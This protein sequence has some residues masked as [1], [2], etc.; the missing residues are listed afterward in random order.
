MKR[1]ILF[2]ALGALALLSACTKDPWAQ[3]EE[4]SWNNDHRILNIKFAGQAGLA[5]VKDVDESTGTVNVQLATDLVPDMS[6]VTL[7]TLELSYKASCN[8]ERG[9][10][11]DFSGAAPVITVTSETGKSRDYTVIMKEFTETIVGKYSLD[12]CRVWGGTGPEFGGCA[13]VNPT[14]KPWCWYDNGHGPGAE[15]DDYLEF[16]LD[17]IL[18]DGNTTGKCIHYGGFDGKHW[19]CLYAAANNKEGDTDID[20]HKYY[21]KIPV[22]ESTWVRD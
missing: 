22:G 10:I 19:N 5:V 2:I 17:E 7:E 16:T 6:K 13:L 21:R 12:S 11:I 4:G 20:L 14:K 3:V 18:P 9:A 8:V 15:Y 1:S